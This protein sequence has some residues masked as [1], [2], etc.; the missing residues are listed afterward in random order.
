MTWVKAGFSGNGWLLA[1]GASTQRRLEMSLA[2]PGQYPG[3]SVHNT[4]CSES[5]GGTPIQEIP[6]GVPARIGFA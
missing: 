6:R 2:K 3:N 4:E 1:R 5:A